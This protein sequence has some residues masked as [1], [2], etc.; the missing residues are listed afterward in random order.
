MQRGQTYFQPAT[1]ST[2]RKRQQLRGHLKDKMP[3]GKEWV[4][5]G[6][7]SWHLWALPSLEPPPRSRCAPAVEILKRNWL[8]LRVVTYG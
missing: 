1:Q 2:R 3:R 5:L 8:G 7:F 4:L 6:V